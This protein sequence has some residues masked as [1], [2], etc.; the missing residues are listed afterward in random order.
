MK[1]SMCRQG[2]A[3]AKDIKDSKKASR[4]KKKIPVTDNRF[5]V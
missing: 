2:R 4:K 1:Q 3:K 5:I